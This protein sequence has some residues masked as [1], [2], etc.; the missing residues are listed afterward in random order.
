MSVTREMVLFAYGEFRRLSLQDLEEGPWIFGRD[1]AHVEHLMHEVAHALDLGI[2]IEHPL[3][4]SI[5]KTISAMPIW[6]QEYCEANAWAIEWHAMQLLE[7]DLITEA[8]VYVAA[9]DQGVTGEV[10]KEALEASDFISGPAL[11]LARYMRGER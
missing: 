2:P 3:S 5:S 11:E 8:D 7:L 9:G 1:A 10:M 4:T 6:K